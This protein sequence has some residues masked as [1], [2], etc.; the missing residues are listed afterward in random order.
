[1]IDQKKTQKFLSAKNV[2]RLFDKS[3]GWAYKHWKNL[4]GMKVGG[5]IIFPP[6]EMFFD[7]VFTKKNLGKIK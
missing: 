1:M 3:P 6:K 2:A 4:G 5:S 7:D